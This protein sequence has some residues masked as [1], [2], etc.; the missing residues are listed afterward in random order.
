[1][2]TQSAAKSGNRVPV[3]PKRQEARL[4]AALN[5]RV[6]GIDVHGKAFHQAVT[7]IDISP[8]GAR[9]NGLT[10]TLNRSDIVGLQSGVEKC[11]FQV[12]WVSGNGDGTFQVG[13]RCLEKGASPW[14]EK[15]KQAGTG[16]RRVHLRYPCDGS[17]S[18]R[19]ADLATP[20]WG[21]LCDISAGGCFVQCVNVAAKGD[22]L[23]AQFDFDAVQMNAVVEVRSSLASLGMGL[24]WCDLGGDGQE[25]LNG[26]LRPLSL[27]RTE[28]DSRKVK[29]L[30]QVEDVHQL[31]AGLRECLDS[32]HTLVD[33]QMVALLNDARE[34][35]TAALN[36]VQT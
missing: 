16:D 2:E 29:A 15:M 33:M 17:A 23:T 20:I 32:D 4:P 19:S 1:M 9:I 3:L 12:S 10:A 36:F 27:N 30:A 21:T 25:K 11:R 14:R 6:L 7:T 26:I 5:V 13:L 8:S 31:V 22:I 18:L 34:K 24:R 35:L 28:A